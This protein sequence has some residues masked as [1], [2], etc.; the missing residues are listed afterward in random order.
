LLVYVIITSFAFII[1][2]GNDSSV[3]ASDYLLKPVDPKR[4]EI[5]L[6]RVSE[7]DVKNE[8]GPRKF[9]AD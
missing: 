5:A 8:P 4:L 2:P 7:K 1:V 3:N 6:S 9:S